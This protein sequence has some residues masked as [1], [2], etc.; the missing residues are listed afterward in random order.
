[1]NT[2]YFKFKNHGRLLNCETRTLVGPVFCWTE[3]VDWLWDAA[4]WNPSEDLLFWLRLLALSITHFTWTPRWIASSS[5]TTTIHSPFNNFVV[6]STS[7]NYVRPTR[8]EETY[9]TLTCEQWKLL[10]RLSIPLR[11]E[12]YWTHGAT[13]VAN[14]VLAVRS[15]ENSIGLLLNP[16]TMAQKLSSILIIIKVII[17]LFL[18]ERI[19]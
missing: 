19:C 4:L 16:P 11:R 8:K 2:I 13:G 14:P 10:L 6:D 3:R 12:A 9:Y 15:Y 18:Y 7:L 1:M 17:V 5:S